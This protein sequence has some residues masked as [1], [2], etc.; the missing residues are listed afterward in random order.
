MNILKQSKNI[1]ILTLFEIKGLDEVDAI[2]AKLKDGFDVNTIDS[3]GR[4]L[5]MQ[6]AIERNHKVMKFLID[7]EAD[8]NLQ[9][10]RLWTALHFAAQNSDHEAVRI[11]LENKGD[12]TKIDDHG[13]SILSTAVLNSKGKCVVIRLLLSF[14]ADAGVKNK[15]GVSALGLA[16]TISNYDIK[17]C[18]DCGETID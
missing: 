7:N 11:L 6:S 3:G 15:S 16:N 9:D 5:L 8:V 4:T 14:G 18:F 2:A 10:E 12:V 1:S 17:R 13:N